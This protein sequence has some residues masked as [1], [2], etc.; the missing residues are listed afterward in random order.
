MDEYSIKR[1]HTYATIITDL[2]N[3]RVVETFKKRDKETVTRHLEQLPH[4]EAIEAVVIDMSGSFRSAV[5]EALGGRAI[6]ADKFHVIARVIKALEMT[7]ASG[8]NVP[9]PKGRRALSS[10][11]AIGCAKAV[12]N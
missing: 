5:Q 7:S 3:R 2:I 6:V 4:K 11:C 8:C 9:S 10:A 12:R 1:Q